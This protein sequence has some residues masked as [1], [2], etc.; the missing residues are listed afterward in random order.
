M[1]PF[2]NAL[3]LAARDQASSTLQI[4]KQVL[5]QGPFAGGVN[6]LL[7]AVPG[8]LVIGPMFHVYH[9]LVG[10]R[11][12]ALVATALTESVVFYG[13]ETRNAAIA[14]NTRPGVVPIREPHPL[15]FT[16]FRSP[17]QPVHP[18]FLIHATRN[19]LAMSGMRLFTFPAQEAIARLAPNM[20]KETKHVAGDMLAN[21][22]VSALSAPLHQLYG[23]VVTQPEGRGITVQGIKDFFKSQYLKDGRISTV[24]GRDVILR[25]AYNATIF[26]IYGGIERTAKRLF[27]KDDG[28]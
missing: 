16:G 22:V 27:G 14:A 25:V 26:T 18:G 6:F 1:T 24:A 23:F 19:V 21:V 7:P 5:K 3:T 17:S 28:H 8:F 20:T 9:E 4:Y 2:R 12:G 11:E 10:N 13:A 15:N